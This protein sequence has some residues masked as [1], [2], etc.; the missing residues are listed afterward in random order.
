[1][2]SIK[3]LLAAVLS[4]AMIGSFAT[5]S[6]AATLDYS[7]EIEFSAT[8]SPAT[9]AP[10][11]DVTISFYMKDITNNET[12]TMSAGGSYGVDFAVNEILTFKSATIGQ[13]FGTETLAKEPVDGF[14]I[15]LLEP[16]SEANVTADAPIFTYVF[17]VSA[18]ATAGTYD[19]ITDWSGAYVGDGDGYE[20][21][22]YSF[23]ASAAKVTVAGGEEAGTSTKTVYAEETYAL[24]NETFDFGSAYDFAK[25]YNVVVKYNDAE[26]KT[27]GWSWKNNL[28]IEGEGT[29]TGKVKFGVK[30]SDTSKYDATLFTF[31]LVEV[32]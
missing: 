9:V 16:S 14:Y 4:V 30:I 22:D 23:D 20:A 28:G 8:V 10:G 13:D 25:K 6:Y 11:E 18:E 21:G 27:Y 2:K 32:Q 12:L 19:L 1:M 29:V 17:T 7:N 31:D 26:T 5:I 3:R 24:S 15:T